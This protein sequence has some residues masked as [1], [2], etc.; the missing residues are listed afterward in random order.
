TLRQQSLLSPAGGS[1]DS[2]KACVNYLT[3]TGRTRYLPRHKTFKPL[4]ASAGV[5]AGISPCCASQSNLAS[6]VLP[7][8]RF[9]GSNAPKF[10]TRNSHKP[11]FLA[12]FFGWS[13]RRDLNP[14]PLVPQ[15][16]ALTGLRH[17]PTETARTIGLS[18]YVD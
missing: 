1:L 18:A 4:P 13:G 3:L 14:R 5:P 2:F 12:G 15:T 16:S 7:E 17:A 10:L 11:L 9:W 8:G 6:P